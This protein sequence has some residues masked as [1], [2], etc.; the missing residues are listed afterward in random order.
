MLIRALAKHTDDI[1]E[2]RVTPT[3]ME[4]YISIVTDKFRFLK[5]STF[6]YFVNNN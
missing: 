1:N 5:S 6:D 4:K 2:I 3:S